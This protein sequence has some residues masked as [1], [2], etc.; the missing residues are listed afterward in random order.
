MDNFEWLEGWGPRFGLYRV[1][2]QTLERTPT[3]A[4]EYFRA[5]AIERRVEPPAPA[6]LPEQK[7]LVA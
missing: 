1:D 6:P 3:P 4:C 2:F 7:A 5:A